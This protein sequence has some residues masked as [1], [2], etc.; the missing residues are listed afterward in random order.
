MASSRKCVGIVREVYNKWERRVPLTPTHV[1]ELVQNGVQ[2]IIQPSSSRIFPDEQY[3]LAGAKVSDDLTPAN[4]IV[5]VK[6]VPVNQLLPEKTYMFFSHTIKAQPENMELLDTVL[7]KK[8][9]LID[10]ECITEGGERNGKRLIAFGGNAGRAGMVAGFRG[11]GERLINM[12]YSTP[13][14]NVGSSYMYTDL[15]R[16]KEA[17]EHA[18]K[19]IKTE[20]LPADLAP[21]TFVFTGNG[22]VS[23]GAQEI[24][25][26]MPHQMVDPSELGSLPRDNRILYGTVVDAQDMVRPIDSQRE[27]TREDYY[28]N[29]HLYEGKF[30][31]AVAPHASMVVNCMY[32]DDRFPRLM[33]RQQLEE[34]RASGNKKLI[35]IADISC[36]IGGSMEFLEYATEIERPFA[37]YD[38]ETKK[39]KDEL[40]GDGVMM[41]SVDILPSE[42]ARESSQQFGDKLLSYMDVL[43]GVDA[44]KPL[45][46]QSTL[47]KELLGACIASNG[48]LTPQY[49][50]I[51]RMRAERERSRNHQYVSEKEKVAGSTCVRL[52][53]H[54]FDTGLINQVLNVI[55]ESDGGFYLVDCQ[56]RPNFIDASAATSSAIVQISM[57]S[58]EELDAI[59]EKIKT[60][61]GLVPGADASVAELPDYCGLDYSKTLRGEKEGAGRADSNTVVKSEEQRKVVC[62]GAG[63][64]AAPLVEYLSRERG[65]EVNIVSAVEGEASRMYRKFGRHNVKP[66]TV[67]VS[68]DRAGLEKLCAE[69]DCV[70]SLLPATM[71]TD[72]AKLCIDH[73]TPL[74]TASYISPEMK[75][76]ND[77]ARAAGIPILCELGLDPGMDHM[78]AMKVIDEVKAHD[79][80]I[81]SFSSVCGG[82]PAP[83]AADN[84]IGYKFSWSPRGV[85]TAALN[86]AQYKHNGKIINIPGEDLLK[87]NERVNFLPAFAIEQIPNRN[88]LPYSEIYGIPE[89]HSIFRGTLRYAGC[90]D[91]LYQLRQFGL[92]NTDT[93]VAIPSTWPE[94]IR[95]LSR[96][97]SYK[98]QPDAEQFLHWLGVYSDNTPLIKGPSIIDTFCT[99]LQDKLAYQPGE[100]DMA[101]MHHEFGVEYANGKKEKRTSTYVGYGSEE[102]DTVMAK[103]VGVTAAIGVQMILQDAVQGRGVLTPTTPDIYVPALARLEVE[104]VRFSEKTFQLD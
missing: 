55:E 60:L 29:P 61:S 68:T 104:G 1:R 34:L 27:F 6:Q 58:R 40:D 103:T 39:M 46:A 76:L 19:K 71:H 63:L 73:R 18:G 66:H 36:D 20:G 57:N 7:Q 42:L 35:G 50:Y 59:I 11:M 31:E 25:R 26:L 2:V 43:A 95:E 49:E 23:K 56:V 45:K 4:V 41:M 78:S 64:V 102:G 74:V 97:A 22:N 70:V 89:A 17:V 38:L 28:R 92:F 54:L 75:E 62:L 99:L 91:I 77:R 83:E 90:C 51:H 101:I 98:L 100:R 16:A 14:V 53:G 12:G 13:F 9:T 79:G 33:T 87:S 24:F 52:E 15:E 84:P 93:S 80:K 86:A 37:L 69:A 32:W 10:Y 5:G 44:R 88:S 85:L 21:M 47:P 96:S 81:V 67:N 94:L 72:V 30:H 48:I 82:L 8:I 65:N 3:V